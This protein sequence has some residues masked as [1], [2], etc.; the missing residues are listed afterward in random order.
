[1]EPN[2]N[3]RELAL[4][5]LAKAE[6]APGWN[7]EAALLSAIAESIDEAERRGANTGA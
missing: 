4:A 7:K 2:S 5:V 3:H 1:M 6:D